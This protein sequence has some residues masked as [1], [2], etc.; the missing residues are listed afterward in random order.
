MRTFEKERQTFKQLIDDP[1]I[2]NMVVV[3]DVLAA[4]VAVS[5]GFDAIFM[6]GY[7]ASADLLG[8]PDRGILDYGQVLDQLRRIIAA[9]DVPVFADADTGYGDIENVK[10]TVREFE[11]AGAAGLFIEDQVWPKRCGHMAGKSVVPTEELV[12]KIKAAVEAR[13]NDD[14]LIMSRTDARQVY[15]LEE[16]IARS[17]AY[18]EAGADMVFVEAPQSK[19]ELRQVVDAFPDVPLMANMIEDGDTPLCTIQELEAMGYALVVHPNAL[20]YADTYA[21][22]ELM[23]ELYQTGKT[24]HAREHMVQFNDFNNFVNLPGLNQ[25]EQNYS[26]ESMAKI[27]E[28][29]GRERW[30]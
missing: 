10:R 14:F 1:K 20:T 3:P 12:A 9:V 15:G 11:Q 27:F 29:W 7:A 5:V 26:K 6:A 17:K 30:I 25:L 2:L 4:K 28:K 16:A 21:D 22:R 13:Q 8:Q 19:D 23:T 24:E 18:H